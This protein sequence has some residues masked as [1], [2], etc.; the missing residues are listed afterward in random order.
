MEQKKISYSLE[1]LK[2]LSSDALNEIITGDK[3]DDQ[4]KKLAAR[5][6]NSRL[7]S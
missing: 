5:V 4:T 2:W 3:Y 1:T 7:Y 6:F